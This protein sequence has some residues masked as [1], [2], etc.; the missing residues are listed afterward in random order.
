MKTLL[1][2]AMLFLPFSSFAQTPPKLDEKLLREAMADRLKDADSAKFKAVKYAPAEAPGLWKMCGDVN[3][4]NTY[5]G[6]AGFTR[7][8]AMVSKDGKKPP[9]YIVMAVGELADTMCQK[10][11]F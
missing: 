3:A 7:F 5:G 2:A 11:E 4:K 6:Y 1:L 8:Y 9:Y 10:I